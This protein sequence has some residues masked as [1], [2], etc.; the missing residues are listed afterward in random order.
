MKYL[1][2]CPIIL[3]FVQ[4]YKKMAHMS[5]FVILII[6]LV[7]VA[8]A[9][10][11]GS[12]AKSAGAFRQQPARRGQP[13]PVRVAARET[14]PEV[15]M[16]LGPEAKP[17]RQ[18]PVRPAAGARAEAPAKSVSPAAQPSPA[19][20]GAPTLKPLSR[21]ALR[22]AVIWGEILNRKF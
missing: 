14:P 12:E 20:A 22:N 1:A 9:R 18:Q 16:P 10:S 11:I 3:I 13:Q 21:D 8:V 19:P 15:H 17:E 2:Y 4:N 6:I 5:G 7:V